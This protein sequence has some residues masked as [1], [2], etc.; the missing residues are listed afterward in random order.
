ML[1]IQFSQSP[2][3]LVQVMVRKCQNFGSAFSRGL[4]LTLFVLAYGIQGR[5]PPNLINLHDSIK[6]WLI[7]RCRFV[8]S[9][10]MQFIIIGYF[11]VF[12]LICQQTPSPDDG[13][14]HLLLYLGIFLEFTI[15]FVAAFAAEDAVKSIFRLPVFWVT[16][17]FLIVPHGILLPPDTP[18]PRR[19][20]FVST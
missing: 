17:R 18:P 15:L 3:N 6:R 8:G 12:H 4:S 2:L 11:L 9:P 14:F 20:S 13:A 19:S 1:G 10:A 5:I 16:P 7:S